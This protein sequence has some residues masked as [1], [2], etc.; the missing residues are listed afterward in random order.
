MLYAVNIMERIKEISRVSRRDSSRV[1][2]R[3]TSTTAALIL[4]IIRSDGLISRTDVAR[5]ADL[6]PSAVTQH[7]DRLVRHG[8]VLDRGLADSTGGRRARSVSFNKNAGYLGCVDLGARGM[9]VAITDLETNILAS[10]TYEV[11]VRAGPEPV[12]GLVREAIQDLVA[13]LGLSDEQVKAV[14]IGLPGPVEARTGRPISPPIMPGW[15][16][17][18]IREFFA[19]YFTCPVYVDNDVNVM[20]LGEQWAGAGRDVDNFLF[21]KVGTGIGCGIVCDGRLYRGTDGC[22]GDIGHIEIEGQSVICRCGNT[23]CLEAVAA[24]PAWVRLAHEAA[25]AGRSPMLA[26]ELAARGALTAGDV[27]A[28]AARGDRASVEIV[29]ESGRLIGHVLAALVNFHNPALILMGGGVSG[30][31]DMWLASI[32]QEIYRRSTPLGSRN[33]VIQ[34]APLAEKAGVIGAA[35]LALESLFSQPGLQRMLAATSP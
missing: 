13:G 1:S 9:N 23:G 17:Y 21:V 35:E 32:R 8:L 34:R 12:L 16:Q 27:S 14:A 18:R 4:D 24:A 30:A 25:T 15:D 29:R 31:S 19:S 11:D 33:L 5:A 6:S 2:A 22:A 3:D 7:I 28:C 26:E 10:E 20:A